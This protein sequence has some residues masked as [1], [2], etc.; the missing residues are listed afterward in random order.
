[1]QKDK[2]NPPKPISIPFEE[3]QI[4]IENHIKTAEHF[5][6][7]A[8]HHMDAAKF[9][10]EGNHLQAELS[11]MV[12]QSHNRIACEGQREDVRQHAIFNIKR[13]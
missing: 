11:T 4:G 8:K 13:S 10:K 3:N 1:M 6:E 9:H 5:T 12:A 2:N 7:A